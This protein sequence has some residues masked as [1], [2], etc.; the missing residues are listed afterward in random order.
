LVFVVSMPRFRAQ[1]LRDNTAGARDTL[2]L[3]GEVAERHGHHDLRALLEEE[4][5]LR[6]RMPDARP[7][8]S[9]R[10]TQVHGYWFDDVRLVTGGGALGAWPVD[11]GR[12]G[13][14]A[15]I[16]TDDKRVYRHTNGGLWSGEA[17]PLRHVDLS[18]GWK[19]AP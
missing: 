16:V 18:R 7:S 15:W 2:L 5:S 19:S 6:H 1:V 13:E 17:R 12:T 14:D 3:V 9:G 4:A 10:R 8:S 11:F